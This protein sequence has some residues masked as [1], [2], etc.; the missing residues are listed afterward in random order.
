VHAVLSRCAVEGKRK[1]S[2][3][4]TPT[5]KGPWTILNGS[6]LVDGDAVSVFMET[7]AALERSTARIKLEVTGPWPPYTFAEDLIAM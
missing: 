3:Q 6:Y 2:V 7:I 1:S 5:G 4:D